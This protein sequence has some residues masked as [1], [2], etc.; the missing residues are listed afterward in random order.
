MGS[1]SQSTMHR[2]RFKSLLAEIAEMLVTADRVSLDTRIAQALASSGEILGAD[3]CNLFVFDP[4]SGYLE[5]AHGWCRAGIVPLPLKDLKGVPAQKLFPWFLERLL[6]REV[7]RVPDMH[8]LEGAASADGE[9]LLQLQI[10]SMLMVP[11]FAGDRPVGAIGIDCADRP[12]VWDQQQ[13]EFLRQVGV[14]LTH[15]LLRVRAEQ[16]VAA[17]AARYRALTQQNQSIVYE[18]SPDGRYRFIGANVRE[19]IGYSYDELIGK[20]FDVVVH[21]EDAKRVEQEFSA[22]IRRN[23]RPPA[24]EYRVFHKDGSLRWHRSV[25]APVRD[26]SGRLVSLVCNALDITDLKRVDAELRRESE[27]TGIL[28]RLAAE[29]INLPIGEL[30]QAIARSLAEL[31]RFVDADRAYIFAYDFG[32][33]VARNT[34]EWCADGVRPHIQDLSAVRVEELRDF[35]DPHRRGEWLQI[36]DVPAYPHQAT[37]ELLASQGIKS[38]IAMPM[39]LGEECSGF[40]GFDSTREHRTYMDAEVRLLQVFAQMLVNMQM[41]ARAESQLEREQQRLADIIDGTDAGTWEWHPAT[42]QMRFNPRWA[43]MMGY[44]ALAD[45]PELG[46]DWV[47]R[48]HRDDLEP[49]LSALTRHLKE[50]TPHLEVEIRMRHRDEHWIWLLLRGRVV[51]RDANGRA[52]LVSGI[53]IDISQHKKTEADLRL[54]ASVFTHSHEGIL[55]TDLDGRIRDVNQS[56]T[57]ITGYARDEVLG[58]NPRILSSGRQSPE[59]Y[60]EMWRSIEQHGHWNGEVWNLRRDGLEYAQS[61]TVSTVRNAAGQALF[62]VGLFSDITAQKHYQ[63]NLERLA[64][65]DSLTGLPN[66]VLLGDRIRQAMSLARRGGHRMAVVY[67]DLDRFN[68]INDTHGHEIGDQVLQEVAARL[69]EAL[70]ETDTIARPGGDEFAAILTGISGE[71]ELDGALARLAEAVGKPLKIRRRTIS[72]TV[73]M[74]VALYPQAGEPEG[75]QL[76]RQADQA[77]YE[78]K[79]MGRNSVRY[80]DSELE[81]VHADRVKQLRRLRQ[82]FENEEFVLH[83]Q[84][85]VDLRT[86]RVHGVEALI[87]WQHPERGLL[88]PAAFLPLLEGDELAFDLDEW[89]LSRA[90][91]DLEGWRRAG[92]EMGVAVNI[93]AG[94]LLREDF[95]EYLRRQLERHPGVPPGCLILEVLETS[96]L[97][98]IAKANAMTRACAALGVRFA[99]DDFGTGFSSLSH[100]KHLPIQLLKIDR[101][102]V[103]DM[104]T[105]PDDLA[106]IEGVT[107]LSRAFGL[108]VLAEGVETDDQVIALLRLGCCLAQGYR[109]ARPMPAKDFPGWLA[110]RPEQAPWPVTAALSQKYL[111]LLFIQAECRAR[112][113]T[114]TASLEGRA[115]THDRK[116]ERSN[117]SPLQQW[118]ET[119]GD[120]PMLSELASRYRRLV[121]SERDLGEL[122]EHG[123]DDRMR[124]SLE[125]FR[126]QCLD[127]IERLDRHM[128]NLGP[129]QGKA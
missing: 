16:E 75:D 24:L 86:G 43:E 4:D 41:R 107:K 47:L 77:M 56:F 100:L 50:K 90:L 89:V 55:I 94:G 39:M 91:R 48:V 97:G 20:H 73:S 116:P 112:L 2:Q 129:V 92:M 14:F 60:R 18:L 105:D 83:Y 12:M 23:E 22:A 127:L 31:G 8:E 64:H 30:D 84:P 106:I 32:A 5:L 67:I 25:A 1:G 126:D 125:T 40:V 69:R 93:S 87:R 104:L 98:D 51:A 29:Y 114:L 101:S 103:L 68:T 36:L 9:R 74:G 42:D 96:M 58:K 7:L 121:R 110:S 49:A 99:L 34:H 21:G 63:H 80:F 72:L 118:L 35:V 27:L 38:L 88:A 3:R 122:P 17:A 109:I 123:D 79:R 117:Q 66:R 113:E 95:A 120:D 6:A 37:R 81:R 82:A 128:V 15:T 124:A 78:A 57:R 119:E 52:S 76:L 111:P 108:E 115:A 85:K 26:A 10:R 61:L 71:R 13:G 45:L 44:S 102:F 59:F 70:R 53:A 19:A 28:F 54:A 62:Y 33:G 65:F 11:M 46:R